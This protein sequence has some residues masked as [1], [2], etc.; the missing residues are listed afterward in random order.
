ML[1]FYEVLEECLEENGK[2]HGK[3]V[4][5][6]ISVKELIK[7][8]SKRGVKNMNRN[9]LISARSNFLTSKIR[10][11]DAEDYISISEFNKEIDGYIY[12]RRIFV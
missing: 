2:V 11:V 12:K 3:Y 6:S 1:N 9:W 7:R 4:E 5:V 10:L 8:L